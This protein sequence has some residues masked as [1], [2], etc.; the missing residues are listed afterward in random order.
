M[1]LP[2][3]HRINEMKL[4]DKTRGNLLY[5]HD[6]HFLLGNKKYYRLYIDDFGDV[7]IKYNDD[8]L[9]Q[10]TLSVHSEDIEFYKELLK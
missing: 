4:K 8:I 5:K 3:L 10:R 1:G 2:I 7:M 9:N 6:F